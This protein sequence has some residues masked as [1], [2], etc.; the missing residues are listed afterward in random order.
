MFLTKQTNNKT[1]VHINFIFSWQIFYESSLMLS[2][3]TGNSSMAITIYQPCQICY[4]DKTHLYQHDNMQYTTNHLWNCPNSSCPMYHYRCLQQKRPDHYARL[5]RHLLKKRYNI[6]QKI[7]Y[8]I[9]KAQF[10]IFIPKGVEGML[11]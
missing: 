8:L 3:L 2:S 5:Y 10:V 6:L 1:L 7:I 9:I 4:L 11:L